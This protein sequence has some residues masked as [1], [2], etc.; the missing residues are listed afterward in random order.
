LDQ[1]KM[2]YPQKGFHKYYYLDYFYSYGH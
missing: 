2:E 1:A